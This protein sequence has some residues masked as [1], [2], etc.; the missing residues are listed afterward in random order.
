[1]GRGRPSVLHH[2]LCLCRCTL[3]YLDFQVW[4]ATHNHVR[5]RHTVHICTLVTPTSFLQIERINTT[6][7]HPQSNGIVER[8]HRR[9]KDTLRAGCATPDWVSYLPWFLFSFR[10]TPHEKSNF[11]LQKQLLDPLLFFLPN[12]LSRLRMIPFT[13]FE[14]CNLPFL[15]PF[16]SHLQP[17]LPLPCH[18]N[19]FPPLSFSFAPPLPPTTRPLLLRPLQGTPPL[20]ALL[21]APNRRQNGHHLC[22]PPKAGLSAT[23]RL[24]RSTPAPRSASC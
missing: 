16:L 9:L 2:S 8:F 7:F 13:F 10:A 24:A 6:A 22:S 3:L 1:M 17:P 21:S 15:A 12:F 20:T 19:S 18:Q 4:R 14:I 5:Q 23:R 11:H